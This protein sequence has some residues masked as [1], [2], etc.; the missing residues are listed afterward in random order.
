MKFMVF[1]PVT[2]WPKLNLAVEV[3]KPTVGDYELMT[4]PRSLMTADEMLIPRHVG[5]SELV[6]E[7]MSECGSW[8]PVAQIDQNTV[9]AIDAMYV[10]NTIVPKPT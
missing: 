6:D 1:F 9:V 8:F 5:K 10:V 4:V 7:I 2:N 3:K